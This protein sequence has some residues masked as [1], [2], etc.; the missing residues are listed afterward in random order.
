MIHVCALYYVD[1]LV[2]QH[3]VSHVITLTSNAA[4]IP[5]PPGVAAERHLRLL[6]NDIVEPGEGLVAPG[7]THVEELVEFALAWDCKAPMLIH[8]WA[9]IS[10]STAA[11]FTALCARNP[12]AAEIDIARRLRAASPTATPNSRIVA[13]ADEI[14]GRNGR[15]IKA[16]AEIGRGATA[17]EGVPFKLP[18]EF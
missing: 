16:V 4:D 11:A 6:M 15:M 1:R 3:G 2:Q 10:R 5:T 13:H 18:A 12:H 7:R 14:L 9:G 8:C 17:S